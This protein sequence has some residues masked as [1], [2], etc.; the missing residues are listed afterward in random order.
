MESLRIVPNLEERGFDV[1]AELGIEQVDRDG[2]VAHTTRLEVGGLPNA[3]AAGRPGVMIAV[4]IPGEPR[5]V[6][7]ETT[8]ALFLGAAD[9][10]RARYGA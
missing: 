1:L 5:V 6:I 10:L 7:A 2:R 3:T 8:L 9:A 4:R